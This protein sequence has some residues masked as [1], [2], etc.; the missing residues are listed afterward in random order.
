VN[1]RAFGCLGIGVILFIGIGVLGLNMATSRAGCPARLVWQD[2]AWEPDREP[3]DA[4][5]IG[6]SSDAPVEIGTTLIGMTS[7][8]V[9]GPAGSAP[10]AGGTNDLPA[11][12]AVECGDGTFQSYHAAASRGAPPSAGR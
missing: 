11:Q 10:V 6:S 12:L 9:Y 7:R 2:E 3:T 8:R 1:W 5:R 4:P